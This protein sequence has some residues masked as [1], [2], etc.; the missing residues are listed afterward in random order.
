MKKTNK[1]IHNNRGAALIT[2][3]IAVAFVSILASAILY[4]SFSN[5]QMKVANYQSKV[6]FYGTEKDMTTVS[7]TL[8]N[9]LASNISDP[10]TALKNDVGYTSVAGI[11]R[12]DTTK[13]A[14][15]VY[16]SA[17]S[18]TVASGDTT[19]V[20][21]TT[22]TDTNVSNFVIEGGGNDH[23]VTLKG[24]QIQHT[25]TQGF[26]HQITT[27]IVFNVHKSSG[28]PDAGGVGEF[29]VMTDNKIT[30]DADGTNTRVVMYGNVFIGPGTY[31]YESGVINPSGVDA[32]VLKG[33][34]IFTQKGD[35]MIIFGNIVLEDTS[36]FNVSGGKLTVLGDIIVG[37][38]ATFVS[39]GEVFFPSCAKVTPS[40]HVPGDLT[41][42]FKGTTANVV[43][44][45]LVD[46]T[47]P[48]VQYL[49]DANYTSILTTLGLNDATDDGLISKILTSDFKKLMSGEEGTIANNG[50][51]GAAKS[52]K[53]TYYGVDYYNLW[54]CEEEMNG[55]KASNALVLNG[56]AASLQDGGN[57]HSTIISVK[58]I[59]ITNSKNMILSQVGGDVFNILTAKSTTDYPG[60]STDTHTVQIKAGN[61]DYKDGKDVVVGSAFQTT[62][63][64]TANSLIGYAS[65]GNN[66]VEQ[67]DTSVG[68]TNWNK[69]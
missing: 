29:S 36:V 62:A 60:Y 35:H 44:K 14:Q 16:P 45:T 25:D 57:L 39:S 52:A 54:F 18:S 51:D 9:T 7:T 66:G 46:A 49:T 59:T 26:E 30:V 43:P 69:R 40:T 10:L 53:T 19:V 8:R 64:Q 15:L 31:K 23:K 28:T 68:Y 24:V 13:L 41:Y 38:N 32:L 1:L 6:N 65:N 37:P 17:S 27:D 20:F 56:A 22:I 34:S 42:G 61:G 11:E 21:S 50:I 12:Y 48:T 63:N 55:N 2:I 5:Y 4:L 33:D 47:N 58:D 3:M 67:I